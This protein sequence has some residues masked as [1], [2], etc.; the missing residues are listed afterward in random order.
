[1]RDSEERKDERK[2]AVRERKEQCGK[3]RSS[4]GKK[5]TMRENEEEERSEG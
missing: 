2:G 3:E 4:A 1:M 5:G